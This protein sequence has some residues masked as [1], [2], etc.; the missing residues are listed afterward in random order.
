MKHLI[1][2]MM[3]LAM[4]M[5]FGTSA[6]AQDV[7]GY[8]IGY[9]NGEI[10]TTSLVK[11]PTA[12]D[13]VS[14]AIYITPEYAATL[15]GNHIS[16]IRAGICSAIHLE[17]LKVWIRQELDGANIAEG[18]AGADDIQKGWNTVDL[19]TPYEIPK[20]TGKGFYIGFSLLQDGR[21][22]GPA[23]L[24]APGT[25]TF[26]LKL[27]D[28]AWEDR[29][30]DGILCVEGIAFGDNLPKNNVELVS[31]STAPKYIMSEGTLDVVAKVRN[32]GTITVTSLDVEA[33]IEGE[34]EP[35]TASAT[36]DIPFGEERDV[37]FVL[38]PHLSSPSPA[39]RT[40]T[41]T[42]TGLNGGVDEN[43]TDNSAATTF[44][45]VEKA[46]RRTVMVEEFTTERCPNCPPAAEKLHA[47][48]HDPRYTD[49]VV[50]VCHHA[51]YYTDWLT[52]PSDV[53]YEWFYNAGGNT[54]APAMMMDR[55]PFYGETSALYCPMTKTSIEER[56]DARL[57]EPTPLS[58][59]VAITDT[60][61]KTA[62]VSVSGERVGET[63]DGLMITVF[64]VENN[65]AARSQAGSGE[66][67]LQQHVNR[68]VNATWGEPIVWN[69]DSYSYECSFELND[70]WNRSNLEIVAIVGQYD[71]ANALN[72]RV[73][74]AGHAYFSGSGINDINASGRTVTAYYDLFGVRLTEPPLKG[75]FIT[76]YS[77]GTT[78]K[79]IS[80]PK[81][82]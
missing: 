80:T 28:A 81:H 23:V 27:G 57:A 77:D 52:I 11:H 73:E 14:S 31:V 5:S 72:C 10:N 67:Y 41:L 48:L 45:V 36:C 25:G 68:A 29:S 35:C 40:M 12:G 50:A 22:A 54:Y 53:E 58:V 79:C 9:C 65:I 66:G 69:S 30:A 19:E 39:A 24:R 34:T 4:A 71:S 59:N 82:N 63:P 16:S 43:M 55:T 26:F 70:K 17:S 6:M 56:I 37:K 32:H 74:N 51:G 7:S 61:D 76:V 15:G 1:M 49:N 64:L 3:V 21:S 20:G 42:I 75:I 8:P 44:E 78:Q 2:I 47:V 46:F 62:A 18:T 33:T 38:T 60:D 13:W